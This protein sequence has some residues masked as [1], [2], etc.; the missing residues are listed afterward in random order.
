MSTHSIDIRDFDGFK[1]HH[2]FYETKLSELSDHQ[3]TLPQEFGGGVSYGFEFSKTSILQLSSMSFETETEFTNGEG[4]LCGAFI[5]LEGTLELEIEGYGSLTASSDQACLFFLNKAKCHCRYRA[6][7]VRLLNFSIEQELMASLAQDYDNSPLGYQADELHIDNALWLLPV[8]PE[9]QDNIRQIYQ[10]ELPAAS[11]KLLIQA[12]VLEILTQLFE[13]R[14]QREN[15]W[16][17]IKSRDL[18]AI[19]NAANTIEQSMQNP[20]NLIE[21]A[22]L[23]GI[24]DNKLKVLFRK[25]FDS[26]VFEY[27]HLKRM[28]KA[29]GLLKH[30]GLSI[31]EIGFEIGLKHAGNFAQKFKQFSGYSPREFRS[32]VQTHEHS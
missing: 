21:L 30:S 10:C 29:Q 5:V 24:N 25:V 4:P 1:T 16:P 7:K 20:P 11:G 6:G 27:L 3:F 31:A 28:Q 22:H 8:S 13:L 17:A 26:T 32:K 15:K 23:V 2:K 19:Y 18:D 12:K 14:Q 9:L